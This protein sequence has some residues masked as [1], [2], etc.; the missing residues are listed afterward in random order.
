[1]QFSIKR[2]LSAEMKKITEILIPSLYPSYS[3]ALDKPYF[4]A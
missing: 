3:V 2:A 4:H 1:M